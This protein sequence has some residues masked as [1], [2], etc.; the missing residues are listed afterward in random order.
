MPER[1]LSN[2]FVFSV[3]HITAFLF[4]GTLVRASALHVGT[5][6]NSEI[7]TKQTKLQYVQH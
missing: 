1:S 4:L 6:F 7:T 5:I 2:T 3:E